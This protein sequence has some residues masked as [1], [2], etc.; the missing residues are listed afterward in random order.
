LPTRIEGWAR[1]MLERPGVFATLAT[2]SAD[3]SPLQAVVWFTLEGDTIV[4]NSKAGRRWPDNLIRD[5]RFSLIIEDGY[6][7]LAV[8]GEAE[9]LHDPVRGQ[10]D[11]ADMARRYHAS[12]PERAERLISDSFQK[13]ERISFLLHPS[14]VSPHPDN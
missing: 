3:G 4:V 8:R 14:S 9:R 13:Q 6:D 11:I 5:P 10:K 2:L 1:S 7:Y 12:E